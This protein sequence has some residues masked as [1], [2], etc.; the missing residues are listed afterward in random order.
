MNKRIHNVFIVQPL[1][2]V[3]IINKAYDEYG[4]EKKSYIPRV[5]K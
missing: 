2:N 3:C 5:G 1:Q 4:K